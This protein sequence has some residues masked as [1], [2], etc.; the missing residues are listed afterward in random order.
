MTTPEHERPG[1]NRFE[2]R[3]ERIVA[4]VQANRRG[5]YR[6]PTWVY[7]TIL[8]LIVAGWVI[9]VIVG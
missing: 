9:F 1:L 4:E 7:A 6:V 2:R 3:R 5:E 8:G